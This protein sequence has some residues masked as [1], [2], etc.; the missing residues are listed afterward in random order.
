MIDNRGG[1]KKSILISGIVIMFLGPLVYAADLNEGFSGLK[2]GSNVSTVDNLSELSQK[3]TVRYYYRFNEIGL[4]YNINVGRVFYGFY[5]DK[6]F[7]VYF[8]INSRK[9]FDKSKEFLIS[10]YGAPRA[11]FRVNETVYIWEHKQI[12]IKMKLNEKSG[13][14]KL[15]YYYMPLSNKLNESRLE[16]NFEQYI[17]L[18]PKE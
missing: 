9:D 14:Q 2:W 1:M 17:K 12:K 5:Q 16:K 3:G 6:F 8:R 10:D 18:V 13:Q 7:A 4:I 11:Q 15:A